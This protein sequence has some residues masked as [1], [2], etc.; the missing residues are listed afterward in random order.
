[1]SMREFEV[2]FVLHSNFYIEANNEDEAR[3]I[4]NNMINARIKEVE[5]TL[6]GVAIDSDDYVTDVVKL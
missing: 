2:N 4:A 5:D 3:E 6:Y 1:M